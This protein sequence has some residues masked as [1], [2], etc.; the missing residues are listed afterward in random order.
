MDYLSAALFLFGSLGVI[1][2]LLLGTFLLSRGTRQPTATYFGGLLLVICIRIGKSI[3]VHYDNNVDRLVLQIGLSACIFIGPLFY[4][5]LRSSIRKERSLQRQDLLGLLLLAVF[6]ILGGSLYPYR[7]F[8]NWWNDYFIHIIYF[9]WAF[10][11]LWGLYEARHFLAKVWKNLRQLNAKDRHLLGVVLA[12]LFISCTY[13]FALYIQGFTYLWGSL[14]FTA[15]FYYLM[16]SELRRRFPRRRQRPVLSTDHQPLQELDQIIDA[17]KLHRNAKLKLAD[18]AAAVGWTPHQLSHL[19]NEHYPHGFAHYIN[20]KRVTEAQ[21]LI[22]G[23]SHL[24]LEGIG[25]E[26]GFNSKSSFYAAFRKHTGLTP[27][28]FKKKAKKT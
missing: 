6:V 18:L 14:I 25:Y 24:S 11:T 2:G 9:V 1:N 10:F 15:V 4:L 12:V 27:A 26:A 21:R 5:Y 17:Q 3:V 23:T 19:L 7:S 8:P 22:L 20:G 28:E 13:F 16:I